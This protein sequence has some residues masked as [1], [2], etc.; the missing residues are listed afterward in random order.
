MEVQKG[1]R[2]LERRATSQYLEL[3][4]KRRIRAHHQRTPM[5]ISTARTRTH[6]RY[7]SQKTKKKGRRIRHKRALIVVNRPLVPTITSDPL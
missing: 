1:R 7:L 2:L 5:I 3:S 6:S 4:E